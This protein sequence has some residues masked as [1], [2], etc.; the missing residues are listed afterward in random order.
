MPSYA[1]RPA[2]SLHLPVTSSPPGQRLQAQE[3]QAQTTSPEK[4]TEAAEEV[5]EAAEEAAEAAEEEPQQQ[6]EDLPD[7]DPAPIRKSS[8]KRSESIVRRSISPPA[9]RQ[10]SSSLATGS[11]EGKL[12][13]QLPAA[14]QQQVLVSSSCWT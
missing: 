8:R 12:S 9:K 13:Q 3:E 14:S 6:D 7:G 4:A 1:L 11:A 5:T 2:S 10:R